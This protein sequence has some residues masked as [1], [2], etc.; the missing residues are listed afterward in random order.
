MLLSPSPASRHGLELVAISS[1][2]ISFSRL[3]FSP[4]ITSV[5]RAPYITLSS[6][7]SFPPVAEE[8]ERR[9][10]RGVEQRK[11][12]TK[13]WRDFSVVAAR[14]PTIRKK[15]RVKEE[16]RREGIWRQAWVTVY[17]VHARLDRKNRSGGRALKSAR[18]HTR[19]IV[20]RSFYLSREFATGTDAATL[21]RR[22]GGGRSRL[23]SLSFSIFLPLLLFFSSLLVPSP[24]FA[25]RRAVPID[26][27]L[28]GRRR[29]V[30]Y[31]S[32]VSSR[33][34]RLHCKVSVQRICANTAFA[35][36]RVYYALPLLFRY[37]HGRKFEERNLSLPYLQSR[38]TR[39]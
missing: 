14:N 8:L 22:A 4:A 6:R 18:V 2:F 15:K 24:R 17:V 5:L 36:S 19:A 27:S 38:R 9:A 34:R 1:H 16:R 20:D 31:K 25:R 28:P 32:D 26:E 7:T 33:T 35:T 30:L 39:R 11:R 23:Y 21:V 37:F 29:R 10:N 12:G 3:S 13:D